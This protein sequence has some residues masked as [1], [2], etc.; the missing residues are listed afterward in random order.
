M[1]NDFDYYQFLLNS[2]A[3]EWNEWRSQHP[4]IKINLSKAYLCDAD[5][6]DANLSSADLTSAELEYAD[7]RD[8]NLSSANLSSTNLSSANLTSAELKDAYLLSADL[9]GVNLLGANLTS[10][11]LTSANLTSAN[12]TSAN[13]LSADLS[14]GDL[15][16]VNLSSANLI[17]TNLVNTC[18]ANTNLNNTVIL[19]LIKALSSSD[20]SVKNDAQDRIL[21]MGLTPLIPELTQKYSQEINNIKGCLILL[22]SYPNKNKIAVLKVV[23]EITGLGLRK[24]KDLIE[25]V[26][27][28]LPVLFTLKEGEKYQQTLEELGAIVTLITY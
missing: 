9:S 11:N 28:L 10:A 26:P 13:L 21:K 1:T 23:R 8:A 14:G 18:L 27:V 2:T 4:E 15:T 17:N 19:L 22:K 20:I 24:T 6:R 12:L 7:L 5:L 16:N 25:S 3:E